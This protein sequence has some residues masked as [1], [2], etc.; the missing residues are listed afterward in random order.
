MSDFHKVKEAIEQRFTL[1]AKHQLFRVQTLE[2]NTLV[3]LYLGTFQDPE[4]R[5]DHNCNCC[6]SFLRQ[7]GDIV[8][9]IDGK[10]ETLWDITVEDEQFQTTVNALH[11]YVITQPIHSVFLSDTQKLGTD[12]NIAKETLT[13]WEHFFVT[14]PKQLVV[15]KDSIDSKKGEVAST[16]QVF[17]RSLKELTIEAC[18]TV[19]D[20]VAQNS[21]YRGEEH[22]P[23][24]LAFL[25]HKRAYEAL[26]D[27]RSKELYIWSNSKENLRIRNTAIGT[28]LVD[29]SEGL[30]LDQAV[31]KFEKVVAPANYKRP[32]ALVTPRMVED[33]KAKV[34]ELGLTSA[35]QRR[36][37]V[38]ADIPVAQVLFVDRS[39]KKELDIF[40][41]LSK[42]ALVNPKKLSK[43]EEVSLETFLQEVLPTAKEIELLLEAK[44]E[45]KFMALTAACAKEASKLF[46]WESD[47][48][49]AYTG[50]VTDSMKE[51]VKIAGGRIEGDLCCRLAWDYKDDLDFHMK[52]PGGYEIYFG[53]LRRKSPN[54]GILDTDA[55]GMDG[56]RDLP[57]ENIVY[58]NKRTMQEGN[59]TLFVNNYSRRSDGIGF[60]VEVEFDGEVHT[61]N[62]PS[63]VRAG[64]TVEVAAITYSKVD[65]F[66]ITSS[67]ESSSIGNSKEIWGIGTNKLH[68]VRLVTQSPNYLNEDAK[69]NRHIF[70]I[71]EGAKSPEAVRGF[72]NEYLRPELQT[73]RKVFEVLGGSLKVPQEDN[74]LAGLGFSTTQQADFIVKVTGSFTRYLKVR[75]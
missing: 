14:L 72:F 31:R 17:G 46:N 48:A 61:F 50:N 40:D 36:Y 1:L 26:K 43:V 5:Q 55:N 25:K 44:H 53:N 34:E 10:V 69:G 29:L 20:L 35:L 42:E 70:F 67:L 11:A 23:A 32:T 6:K 56:M 13:K 38:E 21:L 8:A 33:A 73:H 59:Y 66:T 74:Q 2:R 28:L 41:T 64:S 65:G 51:R 52:E 58:E 63:A 24:V 4:I 39:F 9:I 54:G 57:I 62:Y 45:P 22:K 19:L 12:Y 37:A 68:K 7:Y 30:E 3:D 47:L 15:N 75:V 71:L 18:E 27:E 16:V 60:S 49:W